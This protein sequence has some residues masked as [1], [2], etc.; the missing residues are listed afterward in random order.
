LDLLYKKRFALRRTRDDLK[1]EV[2]FVQRQKIE[3]IGGHALVQGIDRDIEKTF[4]KYESD[5]PEC[6]SVFEELIGK[7]R[8]RKVTIGEE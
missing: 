1:L 3:V 2:P 7:K 6:Q 4:Q 5:T 8:D